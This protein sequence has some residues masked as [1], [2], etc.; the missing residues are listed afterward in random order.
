MSVVVHAAARHSRFEARNSA[1]RL[2]VSWWFPAVTRVR[3]RRRQLPTAALQHVA[4][5]AD[6]LE[7]RTRPSLPRGIWNAFLL[8]VLW[9]HRD[10]SLVWQALR[11]V[12]EPMLPGAEYSRSYNFPV[13]DDRQK[14]PPLCRTGHPDQQL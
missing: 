8:L 13:V 1:R 7:R 5:I 9:S 6:V 12:I 3:R 11:L 2:A 14:D 10:V 4:N